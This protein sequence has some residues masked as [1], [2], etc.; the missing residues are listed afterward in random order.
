MKKLGRDKCVAAS[1]GPPQVST[2]TKTGNRASAQ[3]CERFAA[4]LQRA[5]AVLRDCIQVIE[6]T[7]YH[8]MKLRFAGA[9]VDG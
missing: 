1:T 3:V 8:R 5:T 6:R 4:Q 2:K 9:R 7:A